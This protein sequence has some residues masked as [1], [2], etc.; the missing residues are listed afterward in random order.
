MTE[1][2]AE[3]HGLKD[4]RGCSQTRT[5]RDE[6]GGEVQLAERGKQSD[7]KKK[8]LKKMGNYNT[9]IKEYF[10]DPIV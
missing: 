6:N 7:E 10:L 4:G 3:S 5:T 2:V 8:S 9:R 1:A